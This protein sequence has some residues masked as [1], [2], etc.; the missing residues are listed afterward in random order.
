MN[1]AEKTTNHVADYNHTVLRN[2]QAAITDKDNGYGSSIVTP[3]PAQLQL[4]SFSHPLKLY[5]TWIDWFS[6][7]LT[8][9]TSQP[10]IPVS[11]TS[12]INDLW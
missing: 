1:Y 3:A 6:K 11:L 10:D 7:S 4:Q 8:K 12:S 2:L 9:L 5:T